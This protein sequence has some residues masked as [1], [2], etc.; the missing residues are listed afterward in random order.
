MKVATAAGIL[1]SV[2]LWVVTALVHRG[3]G[4]DSAF[5][6]GFLWTIA[7]T[8]SLGT[9]ASVGLAAVRGVV[10]GL[11]DRQEQLAADIVNR[12][13]ASGAAM[14]V[15]QQEIADQSSRELEAMT[16]VA[17]AEMT[18]AWEDHGAEL[19]RIR[20]KIAAVARQQDARE[21]ATAERERD[22]KLRY[23]NFVR[24]VN[25]LVEKLDAAAIL[26]ESRL[27][28]RQLPFKRNESS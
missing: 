28:P 24:A 23:D 17:V 26:I 8:F 19:A 6:R 25:D 21:Q 14:L 27:P 2:I 15:R 22:M 12:L 3:G 1:I 18:Q 9:A 10:Q 13:T 4:A 7:A 5:V 20:K 16:G 11:H